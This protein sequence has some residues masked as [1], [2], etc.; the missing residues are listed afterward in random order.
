MREGTLYIRDIDTDL[1]FITLNKQEKA[2]SPTTMYRDYAISDRLFHWQSQSTTSDTSNTGR[3]YIH[4]REH[5]NRILLFVR[6]EKSVNQ[7]AEPYY[8]LGPADYVRHEGSRPI[9]IVW[10][11][12]HAMPS[13]L[14]GKTARMVIG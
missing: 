5:N 7:L 10:E 2:Y 14:V 9:S 11:L 12:R 6:E 8:V 3:R 13:H 1:F 4:Q